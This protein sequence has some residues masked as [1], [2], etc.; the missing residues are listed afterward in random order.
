VEQPDGGHQA[1]AADETPKS[2]R[3]VNHDESTPHLRGR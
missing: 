1:D 3:T 2:P